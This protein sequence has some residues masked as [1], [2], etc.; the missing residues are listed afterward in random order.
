MVEPHTSVQV[1]YEVRYDK[2]DESFADVASSHCL[3]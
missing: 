3:G 2:K 1:S